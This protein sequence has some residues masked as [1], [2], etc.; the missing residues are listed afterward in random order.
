MTIVDRR[1]LIHVALLAAAPLLLAQQPPATPPQQPQSIETVIRASA[2]DGKP[3]L[4]VPDFIALTPDAET[5]TIAATIGSVLW[6]DFDFEQEFYMVPRDTYASI[7]PAA[8]IDSVPFDR[9]RELGAEGV[10]IGTVRKTGNG[11]T[12]QVRLV[13]P[14]TAITN[15]AR[16]RLSR[17]LFQWGREHVMRRL[18]EA[19]VEE[20]GRAA[21]DLYGGRLRIPRVPADA[22][23]DAP[24]SVAAMT[25]SPITVLVAG[26]TVEARETTA[27]LLRMVEQDEARAEEHTEVEAARAPERHRPGLV[28]DQL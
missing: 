6:N 23:A 2:G 1:P 15:E 12:V 11:I 7:P 13:N 26:G 14:A 22:A 5:K 20:V 19:Y 3:R 28:D 27:A 10:V 9:W 16:E 17:A 18:V 8:S 24:E 25:R 21:I 4:A